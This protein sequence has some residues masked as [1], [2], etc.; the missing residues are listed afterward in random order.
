MHSPVRLSRMCRRAAV[1]AAA[2]G[3]AAAGCVGPATAPD[4]PPFIRGTITRVGPDRG[5][6]VEGEPGP[7]HREDKAYVRAGAGAALLRRGG[8]RASAADLAVGR[9]VS[10]WITG[11]VLES[12]P[13]QVQARA[14]V[15]EIDPT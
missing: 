12:Y 6:L 2:L 3:A 13:V 9:V 10:V 15:L 8:G 1:L 11:V 7:G 4:E 5:F 14:V